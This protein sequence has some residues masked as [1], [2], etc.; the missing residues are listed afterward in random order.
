MDEVVSDNDS[1]TCSTSY[2]T[3]DNSRPMAYLTLKSYIQ[4]KE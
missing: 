4:M 1:N 2:I 3:S